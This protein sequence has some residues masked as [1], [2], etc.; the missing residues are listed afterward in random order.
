MKLFDPK[1]G[2]GRNAARAE[3]VTIRDPVGLRF[4]E[5]YAAHLPDDALLF[6]SLAVGTI[7]RDCWDAVFGRAL[8][9]SCRDGVGLTPASLRAG[10][11][12]ARSRR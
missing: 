7:H 9:F 1:G 2:W 11:L 4:L 8:G 10:A 12:T 6:P 5:V 3:H